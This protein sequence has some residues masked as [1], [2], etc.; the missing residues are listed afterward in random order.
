MPVGPVVVA[1]SIPEEL[2][3]GWTQYATLLA[4]TIT[5]AWYIRR[6]IFGY[7]IVETTVLV[8]APRQL[9]KLHAS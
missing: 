6:V 2:K 7:G 8:D 5:L 3:H 4:V 9:V 1:P